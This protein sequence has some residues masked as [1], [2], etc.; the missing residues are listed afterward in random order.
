M[1]VW[2]RGGLSDLFRKPNGDF[3]V[4]GSFWMRGTG[5]KF[6]GRG[7]SQ[8]PQMPSAL[9]SSAA[10]TATEPAQKLRAGL[11][12]CWMT[13]FM[14]LEAAVG[15]A[16]RQ[17]RQLGIRLRLGRF[18]VL[19]LR[20]PLVRVVGDFIFQVGNLRAD[21]GAFLGQIRRARGQ[22]AVGPDGGGSVNSEA[23]LLRLLVSAAVKVVELLKAIVLSLPLL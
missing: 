14:G 23:T 7:H 20:V 13:G 11:T 16:L 2:L 15:D 4:V 8:T 9:K 22:G 3:G 19:K 21:R 6:K 18:H 17:I 10:V 5:E 12:F 1:A